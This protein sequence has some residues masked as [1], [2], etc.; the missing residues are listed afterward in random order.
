M[1][2]V[3]VAVAVV[4]GDSGRGRSESQMKLWRR[5]SPQT[6]KRYEVAPQADVAGEADTDLTCQTRLVKID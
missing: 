1:V 2:I 5:C 6:W 3:S 4:G